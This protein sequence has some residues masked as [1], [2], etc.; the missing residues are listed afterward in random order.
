MKIVVITIFFAM[1][2]FLLLGFAGNMLI[3]EVVQEVS[4]DDP[5]TAMVGEKTK[6]QK[7]PYWDLPDLEGNRVLLS[8][9]YGKPLVMTFWASWNELAADQLAMLDEFY[10]QKNKEGLFNIMAINNQE[11]KGKVF[12][13]MSRG[14]YALPVLLDELGAVGQAYGLRQLPTTYF[15][16]KNGVIFETFVGVLDEKTLV[17]KVEKIISE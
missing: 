9:F 11:P 1:A 10:S 3:E 4:V 14:G 17:G 12:N 6:I 8:D 2:G 15:I 5:R 13:F 16:D 7:A